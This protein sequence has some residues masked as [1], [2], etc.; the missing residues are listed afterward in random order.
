MGLIDKSK[1]SIV[2]GQLRC[3]ELRKYL[4]D[5]NCEN[6]VWLCED[7]TGINQKV[8][9]HPASNQLIGLKL[10]IDTKTG[11]PIP[12]TFLANTAEDIESHSKKPF[13]TLV[14]VVL[15]LPLKPGVPPFVLQIYGTDNTFTAENV[16]Q[17]WK[18]TIE[19]L[20]KCVNS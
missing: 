17:R 2:E 8:E 12:F 1:C 4:E 15:A 7:A 6:I 20:K 5:F 10:P 9:Y 16:M 11:M 3:K 19:E 18:H 14:Y 13:A